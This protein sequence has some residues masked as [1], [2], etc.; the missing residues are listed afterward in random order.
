[1]SYEK[2]LANLK[3]NLSKNI[4]KHRKEIGLAQERLALEAGVDRTLVS[5]IEREIA[6]PSL[7]ILFKISIILDVSLS[8]LL[9][10]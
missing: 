1:M 7:E 5:K 3:A 9:G 6:N 4:K 2:E 10:D 8:D